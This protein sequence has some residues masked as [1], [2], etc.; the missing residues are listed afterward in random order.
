MCIAQGP[1][2]RARGV[3]N[4]SLVNEWTLHAALLHLA[5]TVLSIAQN[6]N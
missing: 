4:E 3:A 6:L 1:A 2:S 5:T